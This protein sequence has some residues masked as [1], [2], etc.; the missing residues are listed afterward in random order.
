MPNLNAIHVRD[1]NFMLRS[2]VFVHYDEQL[3]ASHLILDVT[4]V[5]TSYQPSG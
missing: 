4:L 3:R 5:Y 1:L 2:E